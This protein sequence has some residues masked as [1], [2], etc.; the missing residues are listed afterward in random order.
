LPGSEALLRAHYQ[1]VLLETLLLTLV[2]ST[3]HPFVRA[4]FGVRQQQPPS[5]R[6]APAR[7]CHVFHP[8]SVAPVVTNLFISALI[9]YLKGMPHTAWDD[10]QRKRTGKQP[11]V[12]DPLLDRNAAYPKND[13]RPVA[14]SCIAPINFSRFRTTRSFK[15]ALRSVSACTVRRTFSFAT[16]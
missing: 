15:T 14:T 2:V 13:T 11:P 5:A 7:I 10:G 9:S 8:S 12:V 6:H 16:F 4:R 1:E 3:L